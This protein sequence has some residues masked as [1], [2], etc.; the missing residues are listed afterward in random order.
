M[1]SSSV[2]Q[3][4]L[5]RPCFQIAV[6]LSAAAASA[7]AASAAWRPLDAAPPAAGAHNSTDRL[8]YQLVST[9]ASVASSSPRASSSL[10]SPV[11]ARRGESLDS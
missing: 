4:S 1:S 8:L 6:D 10:P 7:G 2:V 11:S 5:W 3:L 9:S